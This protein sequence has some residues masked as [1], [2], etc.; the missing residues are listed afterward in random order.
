MS[1]AGKEWDGGIPVWPGAKGPLAA[2][3]IG[4]VLASFLV[5]RPL[6]KLSSPLGAP[7]PGVIPEAPSGLQ[8]LVRGERLLTYQSENFD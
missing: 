2:V 3:E 7:A 6:A 1:K 8:C 4:V 5:M